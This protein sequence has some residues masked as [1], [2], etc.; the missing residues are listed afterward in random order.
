MLQKNNS[1]SIDC[2]VHFWS[3][4]YKPFVRD[5]C[6]PGRIL[7]AMLDTHSNM[8]AAISIALLKCH[9]VPVSNMLFLG[10][11]QNG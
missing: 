8:T 11:L 4:T 7:R 3:V 6:S 10:I 1:N 9:S 2:H 5:M